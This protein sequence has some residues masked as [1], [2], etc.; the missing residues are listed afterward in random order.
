MYYAVWAI[1]FPKGVL[2]SVW[3]LSGVEDVLVEGGG[4]LLGPGEFAVD[5]SHRMF[6]EGRMERRTDEWSE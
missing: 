4:V 5:D 3:V 2:C 6:F 1:V